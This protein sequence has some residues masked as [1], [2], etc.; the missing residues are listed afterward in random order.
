METLHDRGARVVYGGSAKAPAKPAA[1][2]NVPRT[3]WG[4][5]KFDRSVN[6]SYQ[7][8]IVAARL[9]NDQLKAEL[10]ERTRDQHA[11]YCEDMGMSDSQAQQN[12]SGVLECLKR[13]RSRQALLEHDREYFTERF[14]GEVNNVFEAAKSRSKASLETKPDL[15]QLLRETGGQFHRDAIEPVLEAVAAKPA[16][17]A[18]K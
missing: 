12:V 5:R 17:T 1:P 15:T 11:Q 2:S 13:P 3:S 9:K 7:P 6:G 8:H 16:E 4:A 14:G 10:L 18:Q